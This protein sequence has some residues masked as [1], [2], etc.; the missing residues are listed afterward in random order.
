MKIF[1]T[2]ILA[3]CLYILATPLITTYHIF[4]AIDSVDD[5]KL[6]QYI[7]YPKLRQNLGNQLYDAVEEKIGID[8]EN[9]NFMTNLLAKTGQVVAT[10]SMQ[11]IVTPDNIGIALRSGILN[12]NDDVLTHE[13][14]DFS[15]NDLIHCQYKYMGLNDF[16]VIVDHENYESRAIILLE[17]EGFTQWRITNVTFD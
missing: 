6:S 10:V 11:Y 1:S 7:N 16:I 9:S 14:W 3:I 5:V 2:L 13:L 8:T 15:D 17:R 4:S 12:D